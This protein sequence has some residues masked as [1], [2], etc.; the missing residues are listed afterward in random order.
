V[1]TSVAY[2]KKRLADIGRHDLL[3]AAEAGLVSHFAAAE[4]AG[5]IRRKEVL[6]T[7]SPNQTKK[8]LWALSRIARQAPPLPPKPEP[9]PEFS[10]SLAH[11]KFSQE[12]R[13]IIERLVAAGRADLVIAVTERRISPFQA[14]RIADRGDRRRRILPS[15]LERSTEVLPTPQL[16]APTA[17]SQKSDESPKKTTQDPRGDLPEPKPKKLDV[18]ALI[19]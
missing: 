11:P 4:E 18:R 10:P 15:D 13:D 17:K 19:G 14:A 5:L 16:A 3:Q 6:G 1:S 9:D 12:T 8:R 2:L 7:G